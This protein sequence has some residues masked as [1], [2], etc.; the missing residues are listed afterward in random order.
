MNATCMP[1][2]L[3]NQASKRGCLSD[4][5]VAKFI[6][7]QELENDQMLLFLAGNT[8]EVIQFN[9]IYWLQNAVIAEKP[10]NSHEKGD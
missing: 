8:G 4:V 6:R 10:F 9:S 7:H 5:Q 2:L 3:S 1:P